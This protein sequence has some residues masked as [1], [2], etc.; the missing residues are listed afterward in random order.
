MV[1]N[2]PAPGLQVVLVAVVL[3]AGIYDVRSRRIPNW[4]SLSGIILGIGLNSFL[5]RGM[6]GLTLS[7]KG[8]SLAFGVY[9][10]LYALHAMGAGDV[11]L[12]AAVGSVVGWR[13]WLGIFLITALIG[14]ILALIVVLLR[15]RFRK[16]VVNVGYILGEMAHARAA[17]LSRE[18][19]DVR[20]PYSMGLPHGAVIALGTVFFLA[21]GAL[22]AH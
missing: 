4:V 9:L 21:T 22:L 15:K 10:V 6:P 17:H 1:F 8:L 19:L 20:S 2:L 18:E 14:G 11:K 5:Y 16:T 13:D 12:M 3:L 7:L